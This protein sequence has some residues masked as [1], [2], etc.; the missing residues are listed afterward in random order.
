M[1]VNESEV[2]FTAAI[3]APVISPMTRTFIVEDEAYE[4][5]IGTWW[6]KNE[7]IGVY[8]GYSKNAKFT[9]SNKSAAEEVAFRGT[10]WGTPKYAYYPY[11]AENSNSPQT[12][13]KLTMPASHS[14]NSTFKS[15]TGDFKVG[16]LDSRS[17]FS[18]TFDFKRLVSLFQVSIDATGTELTNSTLRNIRIQVNNNRQIT[19]DCTLNLE[20]Q[21]ITM[22]SFAEGNDCLTIHWSES[23]VLVDSKTRT[24][25]AAAYPSIKKGDELTF[26]ITTDS[27]IATLK[28]TANEN[29]VAN[30][31]YSFPLVLNSFDNLAI[32][33]I[34]SE[35]EGT[36]NPT[37][38]YKILSMKFEAALNPGK[39]LTRTVT[40]N[41]STYK[42]SYTDDPDF[43]AE[44]TVDQENQKITLNLP[45]LN[46]RKL[47]PTITATDGAI[48]AYPGGYI[49]SGET[50]VDFSVHKQIAVGNETTGEVTIY[51]VELTNSGLPVVVINQQTGVT[52]SESESDYAKGSAAWYAATGTKWQPK[53]SDWEMTE[54]VDNFMI[55]F[56]DGS[57][58]LKDKIGNKITSPV[59]ASTRVRGNV[60]QQ[61]PKKPFAVKL[62]SKCGIIDMPAHKRWVLLANW[63]DR[64]LMRNEVAFGIAKVF[65][66]TF[67]DSGMEWNPS[68]EFVELV[69]NGVHVGTY[70]LCEQVKI[71]G[72]RLDIND[73]YDKDDAFSGTASDYGYLLES[74]DA[75]DETSKFTTAN[76][77]PFLFKDDA[78][79]EMVTY[80]QDLVRG[81]ENKL[82]ASNYSGA[83]E[84]MDL[85]SF[86]DF[87]LIQELM[88][89]SE[90]KHPKSCYSYINDG[91]MYAGPLW[92]FD[93]N[94]L[95]TS[96]SYSEEGYSY[97]TSMMDDMSR[98]FHKSSG[99][100]TAPSTSDESYLWYPMLAK[101]TQFKALA[102]ERWNAVS[103][104]LKQ[105][106]SV[107]LPK[108]KNE[109]AASVAV[110]DSMWPL[111][112]KNNPK[113]SSLFGI[114]STF[115]GQTFSCG[116]CGDENMTFEAAV[117]ALQSTLNTRINGMDSFVGNQNW[118]SVTYSKK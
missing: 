3:E 87:W 116:Y 36:N 91:V 52:S 94:T 22:S 98:P 44:C 103:G 51:D 14:Y 62:D 1:Q 18:T 23:P 78:T 64:T 12:A 47:V 93:W 73:P 107:E 26:I 86:V 34:T 11:S 28:V 115:L 39:I 54:G 40:G 85:A 109:I 111:D 79:S 43:A 45:Y 30:G 106:V 104:A 82:Y 105:Y 118:P 60:T 70:Y 71:D 41:A 101:D 81:I 50:E 15:L 110:N 92:D 90:T 8:G 56:P 57:S 2:E 46:N 66:Q 53:D 58:A 77:I 6:D 59:L 97:I 117:A 55:Y 84:Q 31:F 102:A 16:T 88:M 27:Y 38:G 108:V 113:R 42:T 74:D 24:A 100:P 21:N 89:N 72:N 95:P 99:Y 29:H 37:S 96:T 76:Y 48:I 83:Y 112:S 10:I 80:A 25:Y 5:G 33:K 9:S 75:Y 17:W 49:E 20:T 35:D 69:Y 32:E 61:M 65:K 67:P 63:K 7:Q 4:N 13:V 19:G 114:G 68:G